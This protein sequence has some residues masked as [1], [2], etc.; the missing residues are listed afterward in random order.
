[1]KQVYTVHN[2]RPAHEIVYS[3]FMPASSIYIICRHEVT[4]L[5]PNPF[6]DDDKL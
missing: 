6:N 2:F 1:M 3:Y 5:I 4:V